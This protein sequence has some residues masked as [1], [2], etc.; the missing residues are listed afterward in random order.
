MVVGRC[1][2]RTIRLVYVPKFPNPILSIFAET[3]EK[4]VLV[5]TFIME[6]DTFPNCTLYL[7]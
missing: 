3:P 6:A 1:K 7:H 5:D 4:R 2:F